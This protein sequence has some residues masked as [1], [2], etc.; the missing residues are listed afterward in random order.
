MTNK[1]EKKHLLSSIKPNSK[2]TKTLILTFILLNLIFK[3]NSVQQQNK[4]L[5]NET[6]PTTAKDQNKTN[7]LSREFFEIP[8]FPPT[9]NETKAANETNQLQ[10]QTQQT[11]KREKASF[12]PNK[13][14]NSRFSKQTPALISEAKLLNSTC[15]TQWLPAIALFSDYEQA[16]LVQAALENEDNTRCINCKYYSANLLSIFKKDLASLIKLLNIESFSKR[17]PFRCLL[18]L[19]AQQGESLA[20]NSITDKVR[21]NVSEYIYFQAVANQCAAQF[22][23]ELS[24]FLAQRRRFFCAT[25]DQIR[26]MALFDEDQNIIAFKWTLKEA[27]KITF[28]FNNYAQCVSLKENL[29][30]Q[31]FNKV[32]GILA[33]TQ[34]CELKWQKATLMQ[35]GGNFT[36]EGLQGNETLGGGG[37]E[38]GNVGFGRTLI[39][40]I[41]E[42][43]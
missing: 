2:I 25:K 29:Y 14:A 31:T 35:A 12:D 11:Q 20:E 30:P 33:N 13:Y 8:E 41:F 10:N 7:Q 23:K 4:S 22:L 32:Y 43:F 17:D 21:E 42:N 34:A 19:L 36:N 38:T 16:I 9:K 28:L 39:G 40:N 5:N 18:G 15:F 27:E 1:P 26:Q 3:V 6:A 37:N 24:L